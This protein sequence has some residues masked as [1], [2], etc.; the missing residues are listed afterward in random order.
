MEIFPSSIGD[1]SGHCWG[2]NRCRLNW[3][4]SHWVQI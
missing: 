3:I 1:D 2:A 4:S